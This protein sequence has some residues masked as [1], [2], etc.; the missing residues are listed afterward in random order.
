MGK[1]SVVK[2]PRGMTFP[3]MSQLADQQKRRMVGQ[4]DAPPAA[5][6]Q[7]GRRKNSKKE[8]ETSWTQK[9]GM[10]DLIRLF[11]ETPSCRWWRAR[12]HG[13]RFVICFDVEQVADLGG[14][15]LEVLRGAPPA[16]SRTWWTRLAAALRVVLRPVPWRS[17][18]ACGALS[19]RLEHE[20]RGMDAR[21]PRCQGSTGGHEPEAVGK[22]NP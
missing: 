20:V 5:L 22:D 16:T 10:D 15:K 14:K 17:A 21:R 19:H 8:T 2:L 1:T 9:L 3:R 4:P 7:L 18:T 13:H 11:N 12:I 6:R